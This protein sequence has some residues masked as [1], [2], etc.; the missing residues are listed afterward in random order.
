MGH[1]AVYTISN[2]AVAGVPFLLL[3][4]L[5][6]VL[7]PEEYGAIAMFTIIVAF[8]TVGAGLNVHG[9]VMVRYFDQGKFCISTYITTALLI[10]GSTSIA[11]GLIVLTASPLLEK[12]T[13]LPVAWLMLAVI[14]A[15]CQF[16]VQ[17]LLTMWQASRQ[18]TRFAAFRVSHAMVDGTASVLLV[19]VFALSW[20][21]RLVGLSAAWMVSAI[22]ALWLLLRNGWLTTSVS[23]AYAKDAL[24]YGVPLVPHALA[25]LV[26]AMAD[27]FLVTNLLDL[28]ATGIYMV[29]VQV[30]L[31]LQIAA[32]A[33]NKA[34]A[35]WLMAA[36]KQKNNHRDKKIVQYTYGYFGLIL[37]TAFVAGFFSEFIIKIL[38][39]EQ[40]QSAAEVA[41]YILIGNAFVGMY[42]MVTNYVFYSRRTELLSIMT[43]IVGGITLA[44]SWYL[45]QHAGIVG[46][47]QAFMTG[48]ILM[49]LGTWFLANRCHPMPWRLKPI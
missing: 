19:V 46:A 32:D 49:F 1:A 37:T 4:V 39:G 6:R 18:P 16:I 48:Q 35:P 31:I 2:F 28:T 3:P 26:L 17:L 27:R 44:L 29:A 22:A 10:L 13:G 11:L 24:R 5:T 12:L 45:I 36:L 14:V 8:L 42:Y 9:A 43:T 21:G 34:F 7:N 33:F 23:G 38:A 41:R 15:A 25:G 20:E 47:A 40:Y 30:G